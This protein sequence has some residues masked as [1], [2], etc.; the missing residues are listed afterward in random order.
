MIICTPPE[1]ARIGSVVSITYVLV[2]PVKSVSPNPIAD[3]PVFTTPLTF[4]TSVFPPG[5]PPA[6]A[7]ETKSWSAFTLLRVTVIL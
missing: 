4:Q 1:N 5:F 2:A 6:T 7:I 3:S